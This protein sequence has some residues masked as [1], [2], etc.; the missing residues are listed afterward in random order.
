M[1]QSAHTHTHLSSAEIHYGTYYMTITGATVAAAARS[2]LRTMAADVRLLRQP[3]LGALPGLHHS[4]YTRAFFVLR[5]SGGGMHDPV[6]T[7]QS[8]RPSHS[9]P[10]T[11]PTSV[12]LLT[13]E[14]ESNN[15]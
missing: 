7:L 1:T 15:R 4:P 11:P 9:N 2:R 12:K 5:E 3:A 10:T 6:S 14:N 8:N 13:C